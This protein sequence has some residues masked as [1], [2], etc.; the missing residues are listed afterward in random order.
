VCDGSLVEPRHLALSDV[1]MP[2]G[3][4]AA[5]SEATLPLKDWSIRSME[6]ELIRMVLGETRFNITRAARELGINRSTLYN[7]MRDYGLG[8]EERRDLR[9]TV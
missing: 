7:K 9:Q 3:T 6:E 1:Q 4:H 5:E 2:L 8:R